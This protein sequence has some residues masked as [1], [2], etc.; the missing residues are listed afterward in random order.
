MINSI[1][2]ILPRISLL[3]CGTTCSAIFPYVIILKLL[4]RKVDSLTHKIQEQ[5]LLPV[6]T[7]GSIL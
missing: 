3:K 4:S 2:Q 1:K 5:I 7:A 6:L